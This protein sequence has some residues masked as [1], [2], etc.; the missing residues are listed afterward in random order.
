MALL[1]AVVW[2]PGFLGFMDFILSAIG[3]LCRAI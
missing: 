1:A 2:V 3:G